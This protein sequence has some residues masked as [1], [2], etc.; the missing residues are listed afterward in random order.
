MKQVLVKQIAYLSWLL[1]Y[2]HAIS[3]FL[4][5]AF[6]IQTERKMYFIGFHLDTEWGFP[7]R[8]WF[9]RRDKYLFCDL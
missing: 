2:P 6:M 4:C 7:V 9:R 1:K 8:R 5:W 3:L